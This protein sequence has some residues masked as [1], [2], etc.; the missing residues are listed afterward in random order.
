M[1]YF[2]II[3]DGTISYLFRVYPYNDGFCGVITEF[4]AKDIEMLSSLTT[5]ENPMYLRLIGTKIIASIGENEYLLFEYPENMF[6][7]ECVAYSNDNESFTIVNAK[8]STD[9]SLDLNSQI[10]PHVSD[11]ASITWLDKSE[12][13]GNNSWCAAYCLAAIIRT[14]TTNK[15]VYA[16]DCMKDAFGYV[17]STTT[18]FPRSKMALV[19]NKYGLYPTVTEKLVNDYILYDQ[20]ENGRPVIQSMLSFGGKNRH[21][22]V[23]ISYN[24]LNETLGIWNPWFEFSEWYSMSGVYIPTGYPG[25]NDNTYL[26]YRYAYNF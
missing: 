26:P 5:P 20:I 19:A 14:R 6:Q 2:P 10:A 4:L 22:V 18:T 3:C 25:T 16:I 17:P 13:Q 1:Y 9:I 7:E 8:Q 15:N 11:R 21:A 23:L 12:Q 24:F